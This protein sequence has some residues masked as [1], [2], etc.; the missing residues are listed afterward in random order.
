[1]AAFES[2]PGSIALPWLCFFAFMTG[3]GGASAF[4]GSIKTCT[5]S[6]QVGKHRDSPQIA[7]LNWPNHRGTATAFPLS[8]FGLGAFFFSAISS[9]AF[10]DN[11]STFLLLLSIGCLCM[12]YVSVAF[13]RVVPQSQAY[14]PIST[15]EERR[16]SNPLKRTKS[17]DRK[18]VSHQHHQEPGTLPTNPTASESLHRERNKD[19]EAIEFVEPSNDEPDETSS[20]MSKSSSSSPG[21]V[22]YQNQ[23]E[24]SAT[25]H[26]SHHIDI[27]GLALL[28]QV[29]FYQ[30]WLLLGILTGV[31]L[32]TIK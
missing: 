17:T 28:K 22:P 19:S 20:L 32:M 4:S 26:D 23:A 3:I 27:R 15:N 25:H 12:C 21:D 16:G 11:T 18:L 1:M 24:V 13:L 5:F 7:A 14:A 2:G 30:L 9:L 8:A 10:P 6:P 29:E 31:G